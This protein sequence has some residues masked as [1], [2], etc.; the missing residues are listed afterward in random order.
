MAAANG[1]TWN[2]GKTKVTIGKGFSATSFNSDSYSKL[3]TIDASTLGKKVTLKG[4]KLANTIKASNYGS[5]VIGGKG[6]DTIYAGTG[7][8]VIQYAKGDGSD[9]IYN[10]SSSD[11][12]KFTS[13]SLKSIAATAKGTDVVITTAAGGKMTLKAATGKTLNIVNSSGTTAKYVIGR[14]DT[15]NSFTWANG[16]RFIGGSK[17]DT[18]NVNAAGGTIDLTNT[19]LYKSI[20]AVNASKATKGVTIKGGA[21][22]VNITGS[23]YNDTLTGANIAGTTINGGAG[24]DVIKAGSKGGIIIGGKGNDKI[25]AGA[26]ADIIKFAA[27]D[28]KDTIYN[29]NNSKDT[30]RLTAGSVSSYKVVNGNGVITTNNGTITLNGYTNT[31]VYVTGADGKKVSYKASSIT[32]DGLTWNSSKTAVTINNDYKKDIFTMNSSLKS[33]DASKCSTA[34]FWL[35]GN[36]NDNVIKL[37]TGGGWVEGKGGNDTIYI[38]NNTNGITTIVDGGTGNDTIYLGSGKESLYWNSGDDTVYNF[39]GNKDKLNITRGKSTCLYYK[40]YNNDIIVVKRETIDNSDIYK[41]LTLK[42]SNNSAVKKYLAGINISYAEDPRYSEGGMIFNSNKTALTITAQSRSPEVI[43]FLYSGLKTIDASAG[44]RSIRINGNTHDNVI[45]TGSG[46]A[47]VEGYAGNDT[48]YIGSGGAIVD[49]GSGNDT[50][51]LGSGRDSLYWDGRSS[52]GS[53]VIYNFTAGKDTLYYGISNEQGLAY[54]TVGKDLVVTSMN[55]T[56][57]TFKNGNTS[58]MKNYLGSIGIYSSGSY[59]STLGCLSSSVGANQ[60]AASSFMSSISGTAYQP[61]TSS[62]SMLTSGNLSTS[63]LSKIQQQYS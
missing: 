23:A 6:N 46:H 62:S 28:G 45:K 3:V 4:N 8:D 22:K 58:S 63:E 7:A 10:F 52:D 1:I 44:T 11:K 49:G 9:T 39:D 37:G 29:Y 51:Y 35:W 24:N 42:N 17:T 50:I 41:T 12:I 31:S 27:G 13:D 47:W 34:D 19:S 30:I 57:L 60:P 36:S 14:N 21:Q 33:A 53:D 56:T 18:L 61:G 5:T 20:D 26:G 32:A 40:V 43:G 25:Y 16:V 55:N 59:Q 54:K 15:N 38:G 2:S 48:I